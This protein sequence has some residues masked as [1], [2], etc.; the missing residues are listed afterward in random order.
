VWG[1]DS[2]AAERTGPDAAVKSLVA[3]ILSL[4]K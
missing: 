3:W 4:K 2:D 1:A